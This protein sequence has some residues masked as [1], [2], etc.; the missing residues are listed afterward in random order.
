[1][2]SLI[3]CSI[4]QGMRRQ[5]P[6]LIALECLEAVIKHGY[7]TRAADELNLT[8]S[9]VSRQIANLEAYVRQPLFSRVKKRLHPTEAALHFAHKLTPLLEE[10]EQE[11]MRLIS[12]Q[13]ENKMLKLGLLPTFGS[14]WLIPRLAN[15]TEK[16][17]DIHLNIITGLTFE[18][19]AS[20]DVDVA[21]MYGS[22][23]FPGFKNIRIMDEEIVPVIAPANFQNPDIMSY[24]HLQM[25]TRPTAWEDWLSSQ[26]I[27]RSSQTFGPKFENFT[28]MIEAVRSGL[29]VAVLPYMY[30]E[31]DLLNGR[32]IAPFGN[33][34]SSASG[35]YLAT[36]ARESESSKTVLFNKWINSVLPGGKK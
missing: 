20:A 10:L 28:M 13:V 3:Y 14:H 30:I 35:Y 29:G 21:V 26:S 27:D 23:D 12:A 2:N 17:P 36:A 32:L 1:M 22:G 11:T 16:H 9:A 5:L 6:S 15:F 19:F 33:P 8:Q 34:V 24:E 25:A 18:D 7:V 4:N 31:R